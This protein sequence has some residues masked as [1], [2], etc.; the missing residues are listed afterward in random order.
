M[1]RDLL[2]SHFGKD[3][4]RRGWIVRQTKGR[5]LTEDDPVRHIYWIYDDELQFVGEIDPWIA[6][7]G[8]EKKEELP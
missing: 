2:A 8:K 4:L 5:G 3:A 7:K 1:E 6:D